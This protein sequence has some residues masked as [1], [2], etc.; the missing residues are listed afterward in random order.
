M[1]CSLGVRAKTGS[2]LP[3]PQQSDSRRCRDYGRKAKGRVHY[4]FIREQLGLLSS[5][6]VRTFAGEK[7]SNL[8][9]YH[10]GP[11]S[12]HV[13]GGDTYWGVDTIALQVC[14]D[15]GASGWRRRRARWPKGSSKGP[16]CLRRD[17]KRE[18]LD[19]FFNFPPSLL[20]RKNKIG[21]ICFGLESPVPLLRP[22]RLCTA[23]SVNE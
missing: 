2:N 7:P 18:L 5:D 20:G 15:Y 10:V 16:Y 13:E 19:F 11:Q 14:V 23:E 17:R 3:T 1:R 22:R 9:F 8:Y 6:E 4:T 21:L 12:S